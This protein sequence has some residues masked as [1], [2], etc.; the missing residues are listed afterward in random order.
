[1]GPKRT[2]RVSMPRALASSYSESHWLLLSLKAVLGSW[3]TL[4]M[5]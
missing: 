5:W 2:G 4:T 3:S 1:M